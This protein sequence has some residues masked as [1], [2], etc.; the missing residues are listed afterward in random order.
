V[1]ENVFH[2]AVGDFVESPKGNYS[3]QTVADITNTDSIVFTARGAS[4]AWLLLSD[5]IGTEPIEIVIG[6]W[7]ETDIKSTI[8]VGV[9]AM[10]GQ[11]VDTPGILSTTEDRP[12]WIRW[13]ATLIEVGKVR[14]G[15]PLAIE[16]IFWMLAQLYGVLHIFPLYA[17][18]GERC[19]RLNTVYEPRHRDPAQVHPAQ[20]H[21]HLVRS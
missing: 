6:G 3:Y 8:R 7:M 20:C 1:L 9:Q 13:S 17:R 4:D 11:L 16:S 10:P 14:S 21:H 12:F 15:V 5:D 2:A 18:T 19:G